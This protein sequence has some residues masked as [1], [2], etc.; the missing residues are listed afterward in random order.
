MRFVVHWVSEPKLE[1]KNHSVPIGRMLDFLSRSATRHHDAEFWFLTDQNTPAPLGSWKVKR[2]KRRDLNVMG[3]MMRSR[4][5][6]CRG[7]EGPTV[8]CDADT[9][10]VRPLDKL[11]RGDWSMMVPWFPKYLSGVMLVRDMDFAVNFFREAHDRIRDM[12]SCYQLFGADL[13]CTKEMIQQNDGGIRKEQC[14]LICKTVPDTLAG[15]DGWSPGDAYIVNL[16]GGRKRYMEAA[17]CR[18]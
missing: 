2:V 11:F 9:L 1:G 17:F 15:F 13:A 16:K 14:D 6:L 4:S 8:F 12:E 18:I 5:E 10:I 7:I 3:H